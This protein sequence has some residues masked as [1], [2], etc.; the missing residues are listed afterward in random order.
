[1]SSAL[2]REDDE[3]FKLGAVRAG[4][5]RGKPRFSM[6][7]IKL[8]LEAVKRN[9]YILLKKFNQGVSAEAKKQTWT[10]ITNQINGLGEN[11][12]EVRQIMKKWADLKCD[13]RRALRG[14]NGSNVRK[15][16]MGPV[17][18]MVHKILMMSPRG[19][20]ESDF[21]LDE[22]DDFSKVY[23]K[24][25]PPNAPPFSY[26]S[27]TDSSQSIP[28]GASY[29]FSPLSSPEKDLAS[30]PFYSSPDFDLADD[31]EHTMDFEENDDSLFSSYPSSLP[32]PASPSLD[33]LPDNALLRMKPV[34]TYSRNSQNHTTAQNHTSPRPA[35]GPSASTSSA[36][37]PASDPDA[38]SSSAAPPPL[39]P[40]SI[41]NMTFSSLLAPSSS[42][43]P[44]LPPASISTSP[45]SSSPSKSVAANASH[46]E[47]SSSSSLPSV[48]APP[49][50][51]SSSSV[52]SNATSSNSRQP[53]PSS[54][55]VLPPNP[56]PTAGPTVSDPLPGGASHRR[57]REQVAQ[58]ASQ[59]LQQQRASRMLLT[60]VS[61][62]L[63]VLAQSVQLLVESQ[64]EFVQES[65]LLQRETVDVLRDFSNTALT[66]LRDKT[67]GGQLPHPHP[68]AHF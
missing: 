1:M 55:S 39:E 38:A 58:M 24:G 21:D 54:S 17:E 44:P 66:M 20:G 60:S 25:P 28:G 67:N 34:H 32:R 22:E 36:F 61:Q 10:E 11:H 42:F 2:W 64:Q 50:A 40:S 49:A 9:R 52:A 8:L 15:K 4:G 53:S 35:P 19:G 16:S 23:S 59:S 63:E 18:R 37:L 43:T 13:G 51:V 7:E 46:P 62:S 14:P 45:S 3:E 29:D 56:P 31:G 57:A 48:P 65:L 27:L 5:A 47:A 68:A 33:P 41:S 26:L 12:R 30:D 6:T